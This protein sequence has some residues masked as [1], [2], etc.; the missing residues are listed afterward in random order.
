MKK[1]G[2][3]LQQV[4]LFSSLQSTD[5]DVLSSY[6]AWYQ[7]KKG[8]VLFSSGDPGDCLYVLSKG[9]VVICSGRDKESEEVLASFIPGE[10]FGFLDMLC[11]T[12]RDVTAVAET[13]CELL[14]FPG[15]S[16]SLANLLEEQPAVSARMLQQF[17]ASVAGK[18]RDANNLLKENSQWVQDLR[19]QVYTDKLTGLMNKTYLDETLPDVIKRGNTSLLMIKPDNFK[20]IND[21]YGHEAGDMTIQLLGQRLKELLH[22][23][24]LPVRYS[25]NEFAVI[26]PDTG[27]PDA[28]VKAAELQREL[29]SMDLSDTIGKDSTIRLMVSFCIMHCSGTVCDTR[30]MIET[31]HALAMSGRDT[32]GNR[33]LTP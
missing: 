18:I 7:F 15:K 19:N 9:T 5:L 14:A 1:K 12:P 3:L 4:S 24:E 33:L 20:Q 16:Y 2:S 6:S 31:G 8:D 25:G 21:T 32:G 30:E 29:I 22:P 27:Y 17:V 23:E 26:L 28:M 13:D 10:S 11:Q